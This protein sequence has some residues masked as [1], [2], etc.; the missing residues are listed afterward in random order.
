M[1]NYNLGLVVKPLPTASVYAAYGTSSNPVGAELDGTSAN[2]GGLQLT[3]ASINQIFGP[4]EAKAVEVGTKL[5][6]FNRHLL[7]TGALFRTDV[8]NARELVPA[9]FPNAGTIQ[10][11]AAYHV[12]GIDIGAEGKILDK[13]SIFGGIVLMNNRV[14]ASSVPTNVGLPLAFIANQSFNLLAK[15]EVTKDLEVGAQATYRSKI[16]GGTLL[17][18]NQGTVLP[19]YWRFDAFVEGYFLKHYEW[20][21]FVNNIF[22]KLYYDAFY[23]SAAPFVLVAPGRVVGGM[24]TARF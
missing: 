23:Q 19:D 8:S 24:L 18:A 5:E 9:G 22:D 15:Y 21:I 11:G 7:A 3:N 4:V 14:D 20:K 6:F 2:Y 1:V 12:Q 17:A 13:L 16:Y 10:A